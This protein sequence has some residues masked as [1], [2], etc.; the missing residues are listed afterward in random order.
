MTRFLELE[1]AIDIHGVKVV[2]LDD[3]DPHQHPRRLIAGQPLQMSPS[4]HFRF[5]RKEKIK[6]TEA[7][8]T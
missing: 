4:F 6:Y 2:G 1:K 8:A 7:P 3:V 5:K